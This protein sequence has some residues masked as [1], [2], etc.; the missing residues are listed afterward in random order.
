MTGTAEITTLIRDNALL[1]PNAAL[2]FSPPEVTGDVKKG[3]GRSLV[4]ALMPRPPRQAPKAR[5]K[6]AAGKTQV[7]VLQDGQPVPVD[8]STGATNGRM[9]EIT[10]GALKA[11]TEV[12]TETLG[13]SS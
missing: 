9:T 3:S 5:T 6:A 7:W 4:S 1:V 2:R 11:G 13:T 10:G 8:V 12:I